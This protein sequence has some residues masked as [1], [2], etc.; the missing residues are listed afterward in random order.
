MNKMSLTQIAA[1]P[2]QKKKVHILYLTY[3]IVIRSSPVIPRLFYMLL[4]VYQNP[5]H[6]CLGDLTAQVPPESCHAH[7]KSST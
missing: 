6:R 3:C 7:T 2:S 4:V 1:P 5:M